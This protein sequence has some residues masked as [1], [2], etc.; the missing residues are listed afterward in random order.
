MYF[1]KS[2][3]QMCFND[4][5]CE[6]LHRTLKIKG[7]SQK[8]NKQQQQKQQEKETKNHE[9]PY[10]NEYTFRNFWLR[11]VSMWDVHILRNSALHSK[12]L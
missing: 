6:N 2:E 4:R 9:N 5:K 12:V 3:F 10:Q 8:T 11:Q 7:R 1:P